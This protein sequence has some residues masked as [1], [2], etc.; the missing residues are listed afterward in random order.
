MS[1]MPRVSIFMFCRNA[2][3]T[4]KRA[5]DSLVAQTYPN[6]EIVVQD[7]AS[8]DGTLDII[9]SYGDRISLESRPDSGTN[10][11]FLAALRR[12]A[13]EIVGSCLAD[14]ELLPDAVAT[15]VEYFQTHP[16]VDALTGNALITDLD[17]RVTGRF[18]GEPFDLLRYM[19]AEATPYFCASFFR[20]QALLDLGL[21]G[22]E[23]E[24]GCIEFE[25]WNRLGIRRRIAYLPLYLAKYAHHP[26]QASHN[27]S[28]VLENL[29]GRMNVIRGQ[30][31]TGAFAGIDVAV[32]VNLLLRHLAVHYNHLRAVRPD[33]AAIPQI[34]DLMVFIARRYVA[35]ICGALGL[36]FEEGVFRTMFRGAFD[37][38]LD[39]NLGKRLKRLMTKSD[40][41]G[42]GV[43]AANAQPM[44]P[45]GGAYPPY[46]EIP[47]LPAMM[48][49]PIANIFLANGQIGKAVTYLETMAKSRDLDTSPEA[50]QAALK[51]P[52]ET[53]A[54]LLARQQRWVA[55]HIDPSPAAFLPPVKPAAVGPKIR[56]GYH[57][58]F[59]EVPFGRYQVMNFIAHHGP[60]IEAYCY[61]GGKLP[62]EY[63]RHFQFVGDNLENLSD[64]EFTSLVRS[65]DID[66]FVE[67]TGLS[68]GHRFAAMAIRCAPVQ[69]SYINHN[70]TSAVPNVDF[71]IADKIAASPQ[72]DAFFTETIYRV[73]GSFYCF[74]YDPADLPPVVAPPCLAAGHPTFGFFGGNSKVNDVLIGWWAEILHR[75]PQARLLIRNLE[76]SL[77]DVRKNLLGRF[78]RQGIGPER[79]VIE[80][81]G[82]R[83]EILESFARVDVSLDT[84]P[85]AGGN[86]I[87]ESLWQGVPVVTLGGGEFRSSYGASIL[88]AAGLGDLAARSPEQYVEKAVALA[89]D[90]ERLQRLRADLRGM[91]VEHGFGDARRFAA[92]MEQA[93]RDMLAIR[94]RKGA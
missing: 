19:A 64:W 74:T 89:Q 33:A 79:L 44:G 46:M 63:R 36:L 77:A 54:S 52:A 26:E 75:C 30:F 56:V 69:I 29:G 86:T 71:L 62:P 22:D 72:C 70:A 51:D 31:S 68:G 53:P 9:R 13:G 28:D 59:W 37:A 24:R 40:P 39:I 60:E 80:P 16:D 90:R 83:I 5:L 91:I 4:I 66:V 34:H 55:S 76:T 2:R 42:R 20:H 12:C 32:Q 50:C 57:L 65:H 81:G 17:G 49:R 27:S 6:I 15:A 41:S 48:Y 10:E 73:P 3:E 84:W 61:S 82:K 23:W 85:Y 87:A 38:L 25:I 35:G 78:R 11:A 18:I 47:P 94:A 21:D 45:I 92:T 58:A 93:Y 67:M 88:H 1:T 14:E 7:G 8:T 43:A